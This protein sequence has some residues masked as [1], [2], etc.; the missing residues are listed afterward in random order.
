MT[1]KRSWSWV[2]DVFNADTDGDGIGDAEEAAHGTSPTDNDSDNDTYPD[3]RELEDGTDPLDQS[4]FG[5]SPEI[6]EA[7]EE[8]FPFPSVVTV[9]TTV[10]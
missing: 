10:P 1:I 6:T 7:P 9:T 4:D 3:G 8:T 5:T 2:T